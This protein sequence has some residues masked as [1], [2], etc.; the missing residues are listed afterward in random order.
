MWSSLV[1]LNVLSQHHT[2]SFIQLS[3]ISQ[4]VRDWKYVALVL[5]RLFLW[6]FSVVCLVGTGV[7]VLNAPPLYETDEPIPRVCQHPERED[8]WICIFKTDDE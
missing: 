6:I 8:P 1:D 2:V 3:I 5:D 4:T 7:I